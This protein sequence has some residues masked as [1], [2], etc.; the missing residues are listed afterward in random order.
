MIQVGRIIR[1]IFIYGGVNFH[2]Q[3][4]EK[5]SKSGIIEQ[6]KMLSLVYFKLNILYLITLF[7]YTPNS[8]YILCIYIP[9]SNRFSFEILRHSN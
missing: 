4:L 1:T 5:T 2:L 9:K 6:S 7:L 3:R 8:K